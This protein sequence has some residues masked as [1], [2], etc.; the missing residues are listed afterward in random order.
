MDGS[1]SASDFNRGWGSVGHSVRQLRSAIFWQLVVSLC[2]GLLLGTWFFAQ[3]FS[4]EQKRHLVQYVIKHRAA[5]MRAEVL[6]RSSRPA[7][8]SP[9]L[10]SLYQ[11]RT[12]Q[13]LVQQWALRVGFCVAVALLLTGILATLYGRRVMK[14][15]R[16]RGA[17]LVD[18]Q[19]SSTFFRPGRYALFLLSGAV[20]LT[21]ITSSHHD[22]LT[23]YEYTWANAAPAAPA[24]VSFASPDGQGTRGWY[25]DPLEPGFYSHDVVRHYLEMEVV[26]QSFGWFVAQ[27][28]AKLLLWGGALACLGAVA[29][30]VLTR[31]RA[32]AITVAG[33]RIPRHK[34]TSHFLM[35]GS[36]GSGKSEAIK[37]MLDQIRARGERAVVYDISGEYTE[38]FYREG[39]DHILNPLDERCE[40]WNPWAETDDGDFSSL[41]RSL[42]PPNQSKEAFWHEA[43]G[44]L[45]SSTAAKLLEMGVASNHALFRTLTLGSFEDLVKLLA[46][47]PAARYLDPKAGSMPP[48]LLATVTL[49]LIP[50][51]LLPDVK[52]SQPAFSIRDYVRKEDNDA[53]LFLSCREDQ[54]AACRPLLSLW[55]DQAA[56]AILS[57]PVNRDRRVWVILD[58]VDSLQYLPSL[59]GLLGRGRKHGAPTVLGLQCMPQLR[60][61]YG[62]NGAEALA[63]MPQTWL[64]LRTVEPNTAKWLQDAIGHA[65]VEMPQSSMSMGAAGRDGTSIQQNVRERALVLASEI[66]ALP[67]MQ[68][69]LRSQGKTYGVSYA[70][71]ARQKV[72]PFF[73]PRT[74]PK[75][76]AS[77]GG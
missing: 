52:A 31:K 29:H 5:K 61:V 44:E 26:G 63:A 9:D 74:S 17:L 56:N 69:Y 67:D 28:I 20:V 48:N 64:V 40:L 12:A 45:F 25:D 34:E 8:S 60:D 53:W 62:V 39:T 72:A 35:N 70:Y 73:V 59:R 30:T 24:L 15:K 2:A 37:K 36:P 46:R 47:T 11:G 65:E 54:Q 10:V 50:F 22:R 58:E 33:V 23:A 75:V 6:G 66:M 16:L 57:L 41:A 49:K 1:R 55:C 68:G 43:G 14:D 27:G 51:G 77:G 18:A 3:S 13:F 71:R 42:F 7:R 32:H 4:P 21:L 76:R 19:K 38:Y